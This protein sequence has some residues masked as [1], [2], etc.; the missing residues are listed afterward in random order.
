MTDNKYYVK[1]QLTTQV[2]IKKFI[3]IYKKYLYIKNCKYI[4]IIIAIFRFRGFITNNNS[5]V[6]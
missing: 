1:K 2:D 3:I 6:I 4:L 5:I